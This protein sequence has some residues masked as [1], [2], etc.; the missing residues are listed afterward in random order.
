MKIKLNEWNVEKIKTLQAIIEENSFTYDG[1]ALEDAMQKIKDL[2]SFNVKTIELLYKKGVLT[3]EDIKSL[4]AD[5]I[6]FEVDIEII[7]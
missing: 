4:L 5:F 6:C 2:T 3:K 7:D 1:G